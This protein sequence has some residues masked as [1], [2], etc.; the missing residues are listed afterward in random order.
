[1]PEFRSGLSQSLLLA[2]LVAV[3]VLSMAVDGGRET[4][5]GG[6]MSWF[7]GAILDVAA[8]V[9][10]VLAMPVDFVRETF[11]DY[12]DLLMVREENSELRAR[13]AALDEENL[14]LR[15]ALVASGRLQRIA[16]MRDAFEIPMLSSE[17]VGVDASPWFRSALVDRGQVDGVRAGMPVISEQGLV[18]LVRATSTTAARTMLVVDRQSAIDGTVQRSRTRGLVRGRGTDQLEF[19]FVARGHDVEVGD[20]VMTSGL[21]GVYPKGLRMGEVVEILDP[22][23]QLMQTALIEPAVDFGRLEQVFVMLRRGPTMELLYGAEDGD[24]AVAEA[25]DD[26][27]S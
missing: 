6:E 23:S 2:A 19:E 18:G 12:V 7:T 3:A 14:Q 27:A 24:L 22:G 15:E 4:G 17:L 20:L 9:Q 26:P 1:M 11:I 21:G 10:K 16:E 13:V 8:P 25:P 5:E